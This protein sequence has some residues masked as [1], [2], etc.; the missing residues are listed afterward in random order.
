MHSQETIH[1]TERTLP[2]MNEYSSKKRAELASERILQLR[3]LIASCKLCP[4]FCKSRRL[5]GEL[6]E[7][8]LTDSLVISS[9]HLHPGE[10]PVISGFR[11]SGTIFFSGCN[12]SC[13]FCQNYPIS[14]FHSGHTVTPSQL[15]QHMLELQDKQAHNINLVTPTPQ[16]YGIL[17]ALI[18]AWN[19]GLEIPIVYN[20]GGY[21][22]LEVL[23]LL[24]GLIDIYLTD[25]KY[26]DSSC[27]TVSGINDYFERSSI[28]LKEMW[29]QVG[30]IRTD[31]RQIAQSGV[32]VRHLVLPG[33]YSGTGKVF[34]WIA[35]N[36]SNKV[37]ISLMSQYYPSHKAASHSILKRRLKK[38]EY[39][40]ALIYLEK[41]GFTNGWTQPEPFL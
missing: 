30:E 10:E 3:R 18:L 41:Y 24:D 13:L 17:Q 28:A 38:V 39:K 21:E 26:G 27:G 23:Q 40:E 1:H 8:G 16:I 33:N 25:M 35:E 11:G 4:R 20:C 15:A 9:A 29:R 32:I 37:Y 7:C 22:S 6:G 34:K 31:G 36:V 2:V 14:Q 12:L 5:K 19:D